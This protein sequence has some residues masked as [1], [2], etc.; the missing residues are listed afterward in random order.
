MESGTEATATLE[1]VILFQ[2]PLPPP[3]QFREG[4]GGKERERERE[5][6]QFL[7][8]LTRDL[9]AKDTIV[10]CFSFVHCTGVKVGSIDALSVGRKQK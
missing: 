2:R 7:V 3:K 4:G 10:R 9:A 6:A 5:G 1:E 8:E